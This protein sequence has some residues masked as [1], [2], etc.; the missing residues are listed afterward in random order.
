MP[1]IKATMAQL[2]PASRAFCH[3]PTKAADAVREGEKVAEWIQ[4][5]LI[6]ALHFQEACTAC[7]S[8]GL[9]KMGAG[10]T[11]DVKQTISG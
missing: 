7:L 10:G 5:K 11:G 9:H 1:Y 6:T 4:F 3:F 8:A 2:C